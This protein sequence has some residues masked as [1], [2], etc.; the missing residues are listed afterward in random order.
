MKLKK[1]KLSSL[2]NSKRLSKDEMKAIVGGYDYTSDSSCF[3]NCMEYI[4]R[5][6]YKSQNNCDYYGNHFVSGFD[7][8]RYAGSKNYND[9]L[10][11]PSLYDEDNNFNSNLTEFINSCFDSA[12]SG[13]ST[14]EEAA[15]M[16]ENGS[17]DGVMGF[18]LTGCGVAHAVILTGYDSETGTYSYYDPSMSVQGCNQTFS[19]RDLLAAI[20]CKQ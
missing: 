14:G 1:I 17:N 15:N 10:N 6:S 19:E 16:F 13:F 20:D 12:A 8:G 4:G 5:N 11:G 3:F 9:Y 7:D 18:F 2:N